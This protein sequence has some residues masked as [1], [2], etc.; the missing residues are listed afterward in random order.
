MDRQ[1]AY[2]RPAADESRVGVIAV[3]GV[4]HCALSRPGAP[5]RCRRADY[6]R[7]LMMPGV[8]HCGGGPGPDIFGLARGYRCGSPV[9]VRAPAT[10]T[11]A[12]EFREQANSPII[13]LG[14]PKTLGATMNRPGRPR[15]VSCGYST[16]SFS[17]AI[18]VENHEHARSAMLAHV[19]APRFLSWAALED[20]SA[21][22]APLSRFNY[23]RRSARK[24]SRDRRPAHAPRRAAGRGGASDPGIACIVIASIPIV[25]DAKRRDA[26][27]E[28][29]Y[30]TARRTR[31]D[32]SIERSLGDR[33]VQYRKMSAIEVAH[34][35]SGG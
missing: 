16:I 13:Y 12:D 33:L 7:L 29:R 4:G 8:L 10:R 32:H 21:N 28:G 23:T 25:V 31:A 5:A 34:Q 26:R 6:F 24:R 11:P 18:R 30:L 35:V 17:P 27:K 19:L 3:G 22:H 1:E 2:A 14:T 20:A 9:T 15:R